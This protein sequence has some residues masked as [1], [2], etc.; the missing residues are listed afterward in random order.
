V[1]LGFRPKGLVLAS[2]NPGLQRYDAA[3]AETLLR[4]LPRRV[5]ATPGIRGA[6]WMELVPLSGGQAVETFTVVGQPVPPGKPPEAEVN[7]LGGG[8]FRVM[9]IP[10]ASGREFD[11]ALDRP[12][13]DAVVVVNEAMARR[14]WPGRNPVGE[15]L[16]IGGLRTIVGVSRNF[17]TGSFSDEPVPQVYLPLAQ[18]IDESGLGALT[19][20]ARADAAGTDAAA[21]IGG[22]AR[23]LDPSLPVFGIRSFEVEL[24]GQ[25]LAQRLG[26]VLLGLFGVLSLGLAA[27]GIYAVVSY[28]VARRTREIGIRMALGARAADVKTLVLSQSALPIAVG[29]GLGLALG[30]AEARLLREFLFEVPPLD[31]VTFAAVSLLLAACGAAAAWLPARRA[32]RIDPMAALRSE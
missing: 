19:L 22:E 9:G 1:D 30:V 16:D 31:P 11:D 25:L 15:R 29:L 26:S 27:V 17:R 23:R 5:A 18:R 28:S 7:V 13:T 4:E 6:S 21:V 12:G 10:I 24:A 32:S 14:Y 8:F 3:R 2:V 20:V